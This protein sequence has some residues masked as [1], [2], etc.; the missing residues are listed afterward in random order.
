MLDRFSRLFVRARNRFQGVLIK[1][2]Y[3]SCLKKNLWSNSNLSI[4]TV[5][6]DRRDCKLGDLIVFY[7]FLKQLKKVLKNSKIIIIAENGAY[8]EI[9]KEFTFVDSVVFCGGKFTDENLLKSSLNDIQNADLYINLKFLY[10]ER[11]MKVLKI[12]NPKYVFS[13]DKD[14]KCDSFNFSSILCNKSIDDGTMYHV[15]TNFLKLFDVN[16]ELLRYEPIYKYREKKEK[17]NSRKTIGISPYGDAKKRR[18]SD[19][20]VSFV[21]KSI[22]ENSDFYI[23]IFSLPNYKDKLANLAEKEGWKFLNRVTISCNEL[24]L[25][26]VMQKISSYDAVIG[27]DTGSAHAAAMFH[28]PQI[29]FY[30]NDLFCVNLWKIAE[31]NARII[32]TNH[33]RLSSL[34]AYEI[35][36]DIENFV[37]FLKGG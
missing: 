11:D 35:R 29:V 26:Q 18:L 5:V 27:V 22:I 28:I 20:V 21:V 15:L 31:D 1:R 17:C 12:L 13:L 4:S 8:G 24:S 3:D 14:L 34:S 30:N 16:Q 10:L 33:V 23:E 6:V 9:F 7:P 37:T 2:K 19:E 25:K 36:N 32:I